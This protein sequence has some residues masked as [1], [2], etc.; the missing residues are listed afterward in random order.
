MKEIQITDKIRFY[1][2]DNMDFMKDIPD[3][4]YDLAIVDPPYFSGPEKRRYYGSEV[5]KLNIKRKDYKP[6]N[7]SWQIPKE[8]YFKE[9]VRVSKHQIIWGCNYY[10]NFINSV[11][12]I[13]WDKVN[14]TSSFSD[15]EIASASQHDSVR[16]FR[17]MW[18][19][20]MQGCDFQGNM[21]GDK[22]KNQKR[23]HPTEKPVEIYKW[24]LSKYAK[25]GDKILDTHLGSGSIAIACHD[26]GFQLDGC[27]L[28]EDYFNES[29]NRIKNHVSQLKIF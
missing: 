2:C 15:A 1:N 8:E 20:M 7:E 11:G 21:R 17:F 19:G 3:N 14:G 16:L 5:N 29:V 24:I 9:L 4:Y 13:V 27:E 23:I 26:Y 18:N 6:L 22:S 10:S 12:R 25:E 28:N